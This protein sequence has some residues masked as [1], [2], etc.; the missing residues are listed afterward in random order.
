ME[1]KILLTECSEKKYKMREISF[2]SLKYRQKWNFFR[3]EQEENR[4]K[5]L[6]NN[7]DSLK[8]FYTYNFD[9]VKNIV[10]KFIGILDIRF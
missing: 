9:H 6:S 5:V 10:L 4:V 1:T 2:K 3:L 8:S 7:K